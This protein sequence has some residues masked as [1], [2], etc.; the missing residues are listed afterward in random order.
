MQTQ[1]T[2]MQVSKAHAK[3]LQAS[4]DQVSQ[5][6]R[7]QTQ[8]HRLTLFKDLSLDLSQLLSLQTVHL[9]HTEVVFSLVLVLPLLM[10]LTMQL[11]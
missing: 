3:L 10:N 4:Q 6:V 11:Y 7:I 9:D 2:H 8:K 1:F 5:L